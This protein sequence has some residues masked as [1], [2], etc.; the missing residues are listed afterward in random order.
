MASI[1]EVLGRDIAH[2]SDYVPRASGDLDTVEGLENYKLALFHRLITSP[3]SLA[4]RPNYGVG[5]KDFQN[6]PSGL[7]AQ[8]D[9]ARRIQD[10]FELDPRTEA[11][12]GVVFNA[13]DAN[14]ELTEVLVRVKP[15]GYDEITATFTPFGQGVL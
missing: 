13:D 14:P 1:T 2:K 9:L 8:R 7:S 3:G 5:M 6:A 10:Q 11:V 4:W 15:V 12:L